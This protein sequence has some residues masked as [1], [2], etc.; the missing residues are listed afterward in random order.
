[1]VPLSLLL[2]FVTF[3]SSHV[4]A[5]FEVATLEHFLRPP[6]NYEDVENPY[7]C[8]DV[9]PTES[10]VISYFLIRKTHVHPRVIAFYRSNDPF[11]SACTEANLRSIVS[12]Y[13]EA[14]TQ[15]VVIPPNGGRI[16]HWK[17]LSTLSPEW[18]LYT[19]ENIQEGSLIARSLSY[20]LWLKFGAAVN[21]QDFDYDWAD[22]DGR[23]WNDWKGNDMYFVSEDEG[24]DSDAEEDQSWADDSEISHVTTD[25]NDFFFN[26][27][28]PENH[29]EDTARAEM[30][31]ESDR[32]NLYDM[33]IE[34]TPQRWEMEDE[35]ALRP[36]PQG[37][38]PRTNPNREER[39]GGIL[40]QG[41]LENGLVPLYTALERRLL[42]A[43]ASSIV[44]AQSRNREMQ[45]TGA[46]VP[47]EILD[48]YTP[49]DLLRSQGFYIDSDLEDAALAQLRASDIE[50][51]NTGGSAPSEAITSPMTII[52]E[53]DIQI[54]IEPGQQ[55][56]QTE[57]QEP[58]PQGGNPLAQDSPPFLGYPPGGQYTGDVDDFFDFK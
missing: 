38:P 5:L 8:N 13:S 51:E 3:L 30:Q 10:G 7:A 28:S 35:V 32:E 9:P 17:A 1:M 12:F 37:S 52:E 40:I 42:F 47:L 22:I 41:P 25:P 31:T 18:D 14:N 21:V 53:E 46:Y 34:S 58:A 43:D 27:E 44:R 11:T 23:R 16:T 4:S 45:R 6:I 2:I 33:L 50:G 15:Q 29:S 26:A 57:P 19:R 24:T 48:R 49:H 55:Q 54:P 20:M 56:G 36:N 39:R